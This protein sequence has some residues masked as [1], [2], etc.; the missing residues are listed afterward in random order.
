MASSTLRACEEQ[1]RDDIAAQLRGLGAG[2]VAVSPDR[3]VLELES[4]SEGQL[5]VVLGLNEDRVGRPGWARL[6]SASHRERGPDNA[7]GHA[8]MV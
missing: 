8:R 2:H 5:R 1:F 4:T 6:G 3:I 7:P